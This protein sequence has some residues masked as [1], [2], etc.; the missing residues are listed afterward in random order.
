[1]KR[2][3]ILVLAGILILC[4]TGLSQLITTIPAVPIDNQAVTIVFNAALGDKGLMGYTGDV[5][6][7]MGVLTDLSSS[8]SD[9][10]Y[11]KAGWT[12]NLP[13]CKFTRTTTDQYELTM[14]PCIRDFFGVPASEK[15]L[16]M[17][18][19][20]RSP[21]GSKTG[22]AAGGG[23]IFVPVYGVGLTVSILQ[24][25]VFPPVLSLMDSFAVEIMANEADTIALYRDDQLVSKSSGDTLSG[26][27][28][29]DAYGKF[30]IKAIAANDT[31]AVSDSFYYFVR[32]PALVQE[33]PAGT[34]DGINYIDTTTVVLSLFAPGKEF[35]YV[36]GDFN[37]WEIDSNFLMHQTPDGERYWLSINGLVPRREYIF[38]YYVDGTLRVGDPY[39]DKISDPANDKY[40]TDATYPDLLPY[41]AGKTNG[42]ATILQTGQPPYSWQAGDFSPGPYDELVIYELLVRDFTDKHSYKAIIDTL[43]IPGKTWNQRH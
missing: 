39:A 12:V 17:V 13:E 5:Y 4:S 8:G 29:A 3:I 1:M 10:R 2:N 27:I 26:T 40:I 20:F 36:I 32:K 24:P 23:D 25:T 21:D 6:A 22:R 15:I 28:V 42:I 9:W 41:P 16:N 37:D 31:A 19:V 33:L 34:R 30:L 35:V 38:Q 43:R 7:H 11:V 18:F 14:T